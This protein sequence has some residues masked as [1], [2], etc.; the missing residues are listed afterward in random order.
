MWWLTQRKVVGDPI[1]NDEKCVY[2]ISYICHC[3]LVF[4]WKMETACILDLGS[5]IRRRKVRFMLC[6]G[7]WV[8][9]SNATVCHISSKRAN[10]HY[11]ETI[12]LP[13]HLISV[14]VF[15]R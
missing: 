5:S 12:L 3:D 4:S 7:V 1:S 13:R 9:Q 15:Y 11:F 10:R 14:R 2:N 8:E 6:G